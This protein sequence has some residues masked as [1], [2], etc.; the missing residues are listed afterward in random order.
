MNIFNYDRNVDH[1]LPSTYLKIV[2][3]ASIEPANNSDRLEVIKFKEIGWQVVSQKG[4]HV[5]GKKLYYIAPESILPNEFAIAI[6]VHPYLNK[7]KIRVAKLRG[8][9]SEG[10]ICDIDIV[11][12][13][14]PHIYHWEDLPSIG[15]GGDAVP[16]QDIPMHFHKFYKMPNI[17]NEPDTFYEDESVY[18]SEK[19]H[20]TNIRFGRFYHPLTGEVTKY[21]GSHNVVLKEGDNLYWN[22][23]NKSINWNSL[24]INHEFF[25]EVYGWGVQDLKYDLQDQQLKVFAISFNM[26]YLNQEEIELICKVKD[27]PMV[28]KSLIRFDLS[29]VRDIAEA[30]SD[31]TDIHIREG[32]VLVSKSHPDRMAKCLSFRYLDRKEGTERK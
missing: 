3:I 1:C 19:I 9:R 20:G 8:N 26:E 7:S 28:E 30:P 13:W 6:G 31:L 16:S 14:V 22:V 5:V 12:P 32:I 27:I 21:V 2:T 15:M 10:I 25:G 17:M 24:P 11:E 4:L 29:L 23:V 18:E